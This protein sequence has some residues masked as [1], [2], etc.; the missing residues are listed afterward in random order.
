MNLFCKRLLLAIVCAALGWGGGYFMATELFEPWQNE[1]SVMLSF[2]V[3]ASI[4][5]WFIGDIF[6]RAKAK[7]K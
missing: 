3:F 2:S 7:T 5:A 6:L 4:C 1:R